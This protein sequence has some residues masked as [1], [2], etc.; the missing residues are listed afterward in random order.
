M[1]KKFRSTGWKV[2]LAV[3]LISVVGFGTALV[4]EN[5]NADEQT[6]PDAE[7]IWTEP[8][9]GTPVDHY[10]AQVLVN[11]IDTLFFDSLPTNSIMVPVVYGNKYHVRV[12]AVDADDVMGPMSIW[13]LPYTPELDPPPIPP[14]D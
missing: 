6:A 5:K 2:I 8:T 12:A 7:F 3:T 14:A 9:T 13:S 11:D 4:Q 1:E 10:V